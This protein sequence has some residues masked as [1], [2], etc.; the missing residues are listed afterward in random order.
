M[1]TKAR[2]IYKEWLFIILAWMFLMYLYYFIAIYGTAGYWKPGFMTNYVYSWKSHIEL[3]LQGIFF[4]LMF[5]LINHIF[6]K[7]VMRKRSF[8]FIVTAKSVLY[9]IAMLVVGMFVNLIYLVFDIVPYEHMMEQ[10]AEM[11]T[12]PFIL[13]FVTYIILA[14]ILINFILQVNRKFGPGN[15]FSIL[16]GKYHNPAVENRIFLFL[17]LRS[18]TTIAEK[19]GH[20]TYS[21]F[22]QA[23][24]QDLTDIIIRYRADI[25]QYVGDEVV[26]TWKEKTGLK[27][28]NCIKAYFAYELK[29]GS[30]RSFYE[31]RFGVFPEFCGGMDIGPVTVAEVGEIKREIAYHGDVLNTASRLQEQCKK[32]GRRLLI[33]HHLAE[34]MPASNGFD[35]HLLGEVPLRGKTQPVRIYSMELI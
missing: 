15:L 4:G 5:A 24:F 30:R 13:S 21:S 10:A 22:L 32:F 14:I 17:D 9:M 23:C 34:Y 20:R 3:W 27:N 12:V 16:S 2:V 1:D 28:L 7:T 6:D 18:S 31:N 11:L 33:S 29:L 19:L 26:L 25:Y 8:G 35:T